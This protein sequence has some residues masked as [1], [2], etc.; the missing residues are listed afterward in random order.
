[1]HSRL[2]Q[3]DA[4]ERSQTSRAASPTRRAARL[5][6]AAPAPR[7]RGAAA[8]HGA[9]VVEMQRRRLLYAIGELAGEQAL[10]GAGV[11]TICKRGGVSR[12]TFYELFED[13]EAC[14]L[15]ALGDALDRLGSTVSAAY[16]SDGT[17]AERVRA[18]LDCLLELLDRE[19]G[20]ARLC[21]VETLRAG[22][23]ALAW[24]KRVLEA[25]A[26]AVDEGRA[27]SKH[28]KE[29]P[30]LTAD[31]VVGGALS[32]LHARLLDP[33]LAPL[34]ELEEPLWAMIVH[35]YLGPVGARRE[36]SRLSAAGPSQSAPY[37]SADRRRHRNG[38]VS[39]PSEGRDSVGNP[40]KGLPIRFTYRTA[41]VM[42][43]IALHPGAS[44][45]T[46]ALGAEI[47]DEGQMSR[48]LRR[49]EG[50]GLVENQSDGHT[51]GE[52]NAWALTPRG[53]AV[54]AALGTRPT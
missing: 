40:F 30:T 19:P 14:V 43:T 31:G 29:L 54:N 9:H 36:S 24:R 49:L 32:V 42:A 8:G 50:C 33:D 15:A 28:G 37:R 4:P 48:L 35:P 34:R 5:G 7:A 52:A 26:L 11:G 16:A 25:L 46:I 51:R 12:R 27:E 6:A 21:V 39:N 38:S 10:D 17:W 44:N 20:I 53:E 1:M 3:A 41:R 2:M 45:R 47:G 22:P 23:A 13:R 18:A